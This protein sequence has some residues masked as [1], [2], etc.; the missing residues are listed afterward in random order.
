MREWRGHGSPF[1]LTNRG[2]RAIW[3]VVW[4]LCFRPSPKMAYGWRNALL[5]AFG[6][7]VGKGVHVLPSARIWAP[8]RLE[9]GDGSCVG[10]HV[11]CYCAERIRL[12]R[13]ATI[14]QY[15]FLCTASHDHERDGMPSICKPILIGDWAWVCADV[16]VAPGVTIGEGAVAGARAS[17]FRDVVPWTIVGGNPARVLGNRTWRPGASHLEAGRVSD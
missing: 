12:G 9:L 5:R 2:V 1:S 11:D 14:S 15:S 3:G 16:Y 8:W 6:A 13:G 10:E 4:L 17:V 7:Q